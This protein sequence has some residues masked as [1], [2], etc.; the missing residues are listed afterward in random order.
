MSENLI[1][2]VAPQLSP[3]VQRQ[4]IGTAG[5]DDGVTQSFITIGPITIAF[6]DDDAE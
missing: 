6:A 5:N 1:E 4:P 2:S 3:P